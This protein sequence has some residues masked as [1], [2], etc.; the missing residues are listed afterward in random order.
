MEANLYVSRLMKG[1]LVKTKEEAE[2]MG[3]P[4]GSGL[5]ERYTKFSKTTLNLGESALTT[6]QK[7]VIFAASKQPVCVKSIGNFLKGLVLFQKN[8]FFHGLFF[9]L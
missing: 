6:T 3:L 8:N 1:S 4:D 7:W 9:N 5:F 2:N